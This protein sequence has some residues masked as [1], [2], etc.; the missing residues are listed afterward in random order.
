VLGCTTGLM[1]V[2]ECM[3]VVLV[4]ACESV[5]WVCKSGLMVAVV[6]ACKE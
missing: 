1:V 6:L 2:G 4:L 5:V 3:R